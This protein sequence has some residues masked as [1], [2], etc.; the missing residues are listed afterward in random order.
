M[1]ILIFLLTFQGFAF[2]AFSNISD[3]KLHTVK[4]MFGT[5]AIQRIQYMQNQ[6][7]KIA[8]ENYTYTK[9]H[10]VNTLI[11]KL[12]YKQ[13][14]LHWKNNHTATFL[15][16]VASGAGDSLDF[17]AAKYVTLVNLGF[18]Q[19]RL[20]FFKMNK[21]KRNQLQEDHYVL[22]YVPKNSKEYFILDCCNNEIIPA[23]RGNLKLKFS[24]ITRKEK[25]W[26][27]HNMQKIHFVQNNQFLQV[28]LKN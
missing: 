3:T 20:K 12:L 19:K 6:F 4:K 7:D 26:M 23:L 5:K 22:G 24:D 18:D 8:H 16:F 9:I 10:R 11:N 28:E 13:N 25:I 27:L 17:A 15:E 21:Q 2:A 14:K 1:K